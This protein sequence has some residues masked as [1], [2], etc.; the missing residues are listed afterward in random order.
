MNGVWLTCDK[1]VTPSRFM[2]T[3]KPVQLY[4]EHFAN[5]LDKVPMVNILPFGVCSVTRTPCMPAPVMWERVMEDGLTVLGARPLLDTSKCMCGVGGK[6]AIHFTKADATAAVELDQKL[7]QIDAAADAAMEASTW[8]FWGGVAMAVG[9][10]VLCATGVAAPLGAAMIAGGGHLITASTVLASAAAITKGVTSFVRDPSLQNGLSIVGE[11]VKE[12]A[13]NYVMN[14][15]G[16]AVVK[17]LGQFA[18][19]AMKRLNLSERACRLA[20]RTLCTVTGHPV[21]VISGYLYTEA[22]DFELAGPIPLRWERLWNSTSIHD[23]PLGHGWHHSYDMALCVEAE[24]QVVAFRAADGRGIAF[25]LVPLGGQDYNRL[26]KLTLLRDEQGY[27]VVDHAQNLT[28]RF[29]PNRGDE[30]MPLAAIE[31][32]NG[33]SIRFRYDGAGY[34]T[35]IED[36]AHR[37]LQ[38][39][40][41]SQGRILHIKA[42]HP[43]EPRQT[44]RLVEYRYNRRGELVSALD[45]L[46]QAAHYRY[47]NR[48]LVQETFKHGLNFYFQYEGSGPEARCVRTW[49]D[50]GIYDHQLRYDVDAHRTV[51]TD[52]LG[53]A[54]TYVGNENGLV[55]ETIDARGGVT[56]TAYNEYNELL[57]ETDALGNQTLFQYDERGNTIQL[58]K[59]DGAALQF[60]YDAADRPVAAT[61]AAGGEWQWRYDAAGNLLESTDPLGNVTRYTYEHGLLRRIADAGP[62]PGERRY[63]DAGN[64]VEEYTPA[65]QRTRWLYDGWGRA[66]KT[67]D[68][69]G[70]VQWQEYDLLGRPVKVYEPDGNVRTLT[71]D[72]FDNVVHYHDRHQDVRYVYQGMGR[73][74]RRVEAGTAVEL[75]YDSEQRL[76]AVVNEHGLTYRFELDPVGDVLSETSFDGSTHRYLRDAGGHVVELLLPSGQRTRYAYDRA[77]R[78]EE[79]THADGSRETFRYR[80]DGHLLEATNQWGTVQFERDVLGRV[81]TETQG[82]HAV[83]SS[84][85]APGRRVRLQSTLGADVRFDHDAGGHLA[86]IE[87]NRWQV[88]FE[89]DAQGLELQRT[90]SR[91]RSRWKHDALGRPTEQRIGTGPGSPERVRSY[92]WQPADRLAQIQDSRSGLTRF[93]H[94]A[95]GHLT[96]ATFADG[97]QQRRYADAVGNL[98]AGASAL[99]RRYGPAGQLLEAGGTRYEYDATGNLQRKVTAAGEEWTYQW[100]GAGYLTEVLRPDGEQVRFAYDALGRRVSKSYRQQLTRW[101]WNGDQPLHEWTEPETAARPEAD[102]VTWLFEEDSFAPVAKLQGAASQGI[103][104]DYQGTPLEMYEPDGRLTWQAELDT[105]GRVRPGA[106]GQAG[107]CPFR[108]QGQYEDVETGLYYN[109]FRYYDPAAG[110]YIS[111]DPIRL[112]GGLELYGYVA[113]P[114][115]WLDPFG[116][117]KTPTS[118]LRR[119][120]TQYSGTKSTGQVHHGLPE[121]LAGDFKKLANIKVNNGKYF[122]DLTPQQHILRPHGI[123]TKG[124]PLGQEWNAHW[125]EWLAKNQATLA[126]GSK[127]QARRM[128]EQHLDDIADRAGISGNRARKRTSPPC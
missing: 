41:D 92:G 1:G 82:P 75:L 127:R 2:V 121:Q 45:A 97:T 102:L 70:N 99:D 37:L 109:R 35:E 101:V 61:D 123:H 113:D 100:N 59:A 34:L 56:L 94:D 8:A 84:Y 73:L 124:S 44:V 23:G 5:E 63:D 4:D 7:D 16:G 81:L 11:V 48:L 72:A 6:M 50:G 117:A 104:C 103:V 30:V 19:K 10:A 87:A 85:D 118:T 18:Q 52:S 60:S 107:A 43:T 120:W 49:G 32:P 66:L 76:R 74:I 91:V 115:V 57:S 15:L 90:F 14:K 122:F 27:A 29:G 13:I 12:L 110:L 33:F 54:T 62:Q 53:H 39:S 108:Y 26:E 46:G 9:G 119:I 55:E 95:R 125:R 106:A 112:A 31:H 128:I 86:R 38:V 17:R 67:T 58:T 98:F 71:Y 68:A 20:N 22:V 79:V 65:G 40:T 25:D 28:Y 51:V 3:P 36:S 47:D 42:P 21:D 78:I 96:A 83:S 77:G 88:R 80:P 126:G 105:Y 114:L 93:G 24:Q 69:R 89:R 111:Q 64:L 116:L